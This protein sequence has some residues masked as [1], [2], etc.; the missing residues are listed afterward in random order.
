M[1]KSGQKKMVSIRNS[2]SIHRTAF[3]ISREINRGQ[4]ILDKIQTVLTS[5]RYDTGARN[6]EKISPGQI[7]QYLQNLIEKIED[8]KLSRV[9]AASYVS[10]LN[11]ALSYASRGDLLVSAKEYGLSRGSHTPADL[12]NALSSRDHFL[13]FLQDKASKTGNTNYSA[14]NISVRLQGELGLRFR[15]SVRIQARTIDAALKSGILHLHARGDGTKNGR[16]RDIPLSSQQINILRS[17][18]DFLRGNKQHNLIDPNKAY[19]EYKD[20]AYDALKAFT[21]SSN[22]YFHFHGER[23]AFAHQLFSSL[24]QQQTGKSILPPVIAG[25]RGAD[26]VKYAQSKTGLPENKIKEMDKEIRLEVSHQLGHNRINVT[27]DYLG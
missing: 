20:F 11:T 21:S 5:L 13:Q 7:E 17:T 9:T 27:R 8:E 24:W 1:I 16:A 10:A 2:S 15:E 14:L 19:K 26:W 22:S 3:L 18:R 25:L 4:A 6:I 23:H 12:A